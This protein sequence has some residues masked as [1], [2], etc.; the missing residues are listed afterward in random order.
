[1][2]PSRKKKFF[3]EETSS[4]EQGGKTPGARNQ[5]REERSME[6]KIMFSV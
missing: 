3:E 1:M 4:S 5:F 2:L 6:M